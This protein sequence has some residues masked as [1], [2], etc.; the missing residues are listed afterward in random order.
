MVQPAVVHFD[1][2]PLSAR[3]VHFDVRPL[4]ARTV[5]AHYEVAR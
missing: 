1:V 2:R 5:A 3:S 4:S